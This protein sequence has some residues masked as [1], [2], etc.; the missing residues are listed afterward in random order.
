MSFVLIYYACINRSV[1]DIWSGTNG[2]I[3]DVTM[4]LTGMKIS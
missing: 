1:L 3:P 4:Y 2:L